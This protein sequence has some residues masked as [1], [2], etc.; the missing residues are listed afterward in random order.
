MNY[1]LYMAK[2][3]N[4]LYVDIN[5]HVFLVLKHSFMYLLKCINT[6]Y[7]NDTQ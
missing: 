2:F 7:I 3:V 6:F 4:I 1:K 5:D